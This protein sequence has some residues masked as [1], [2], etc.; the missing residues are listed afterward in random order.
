MEQFLEIAKINP[1]LLFL[2]KALKHLYLVRR[3][4]ARELL[5]MQP[6]WD[7]AHHRRVDFQDRQRVL[8]PHDK[9]LEEVRSAAVTPHIGKVKPLD[10]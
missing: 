9:L 10:A 1:T 3:V 6:I 5:Q 2:H 7:D 8:G 4:P